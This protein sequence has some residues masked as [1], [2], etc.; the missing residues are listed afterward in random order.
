MKKLLIILI[1]AF[2]SLNAIAFEAKDVFI[3][4]EINFFEEPKTVNI[5]IDNLS[6]QNKSLRIEFIGP[7]TLLYEFTEK[8]SDVLAEERTEAKLLIYPSKNLLNSS[9]NASIIVY[10]G[11]EKVIKTIKLN[12]YE[13]A[14]TEKPKNNLLEP[15]TEN[16]KNSAAFV[17]LTLNDSKYSYYNRL[18]LAIIVLLLILL[19]VRYYNKRKK[20]E[21]KEKT[22]KWG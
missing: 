7:T 9:Y 11:N 20:E 17:L 5:I 12:F 4:N 2:L 22:K 1:I 21:I 13:K 16:T 10:L 6:N 3:D 8:P 19:I 18:L 15:L 14:N